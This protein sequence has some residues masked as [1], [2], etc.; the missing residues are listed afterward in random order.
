MTDTEVRPVPVRRPAP[1]R[2]VIPPEA[3][4]IVDVADLARQNSELLERLE[5][6]ERGGTRFVDSAP[7]NVIGE[8]RQ[9]DDAELTDWQRELRQQTRPKDP[10]S[11]VRNEPGYN[12]PQRYY[13]RPDGDIVKLQADSKNLA[14]YTDTKGFRVLSPSEARHYEAIERPQIIKLQ[15]NRANL[16][17]GIRQAVARDMTLAVGLPLTWE[18]DVDHMTVPELQGLFDDIAG[19]PTSDGKPRKMFKRLQRLQDAD[20]AR[21]DA[22]AKHLLAGVETGRRGMDELDRL[23]GY[24]RPRTPPT[25][26][27]EVTAANADAFKFA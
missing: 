10:A 25:R 16:I 13:M 23:T 9:A 2:K 6:L 8:Q 1:R 7:Q 12:V 27:V 26:Q 14:Y 4:D 11:I 5:R 22:E 20:D 15:Q 24:D 3:S 17:N 21:A 19:T 18:G